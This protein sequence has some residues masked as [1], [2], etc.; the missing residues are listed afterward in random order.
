MSEESRSAAANHQAP[1]LAEPVTGNYFVSTY[2]PFF[3]WKKEEVAAVEPALEQTLAT[4]PP[5]GLYFH[6]P[7]CVQRCHYCYYL[8]YEGCGEEM[9]P[10]LD[11]LLTE[12]TR[13]H[14][15]GTTPNSRSNAH[16]KPSPRRK[17]A[18]SGMAA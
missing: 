5:L 13:R 15:G 11:A 4:A 12:L 7:F 17:C 18:L 8:S 10:Y 14:P 9:E 16:P 6:I 2:P 1:A 3:Y